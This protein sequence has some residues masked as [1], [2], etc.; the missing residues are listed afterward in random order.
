[1]AWSNVSR[2]VSDDFYEELHVTPDADARDIKKAYFGL[3]RQFPPETHPEAFQKIRA[4]Y[5]VLSDPEARKAYD[6]TRSV[7]ASADLGDELA[8]IMRS[9]LEAIELEEYERAVPLLE[10]VVKERPTAQE[11]RVQLCSCLLRLNRLADAGRE[12]QEL[13]RH[14]PTL[15]RAPLFAGYA[16]L[17][18]K[19]TAE[20]RGHFVRAALLDPLDLRPVRS[21]VDVDL[22]N[23]NGREALAWLD[24]RLAT[25]PES[26][27]LGLRMERVSV[28]LFLERGDEVTRVLNELEREAE[29]PELKEELGWFYEREA[30][31]LFA[32]RKHERAD[33]MIA[34]LMAFAPARG[35]AVLTRPVTLPISSLSPDALA[36]LVA[37]R[38]KPELVYLP[39]VGLFIDS[40]LVLVAG[41]LFGAAVMMGFNGNGVWST[42]E[43]SF[44]AL[45]FG[46][47]GATACIALRRW[48]RTMKSPVGR[49]MTLHPLY[50]IDVDIDEVRF[51]PM[52]RMSEIRA[53]HQ[54]SNGAYTHTTFA[55]FFGLESR[56]FTV[57]SQQGAED[58]AKQLY[59]LRGRLLDLLHSGLLA[60]EAG[61]DLLSAAL[62][63]QPPPRAPRWHWLRWPVAG[64]ALGV[65]LSFFAAVV[66]QRTFEQGNWSAVANDGSPRALQGYL[67][68]APA[69][70]FTESAKAA[71][72]Q[73]QR[74]AVSRLRLSA[75]QLARALEGAT[76]GTPVTLF[77]DV[78]GEAEHPVLVAPKGAQLADLPES[79]FKARG[80]RE[81]ELVE[82]LQR[83]IDAEAGPGWFVVRQGTGPLVLS[84]K[85]R[86]SLTGGAYR[87]K[88]PGPDLDLLWPEARLEATGRFGATEKTLVAS[89][90][91]VV[92][93]TRLSVQAL[94]R[95]GTSAASG[96]LFDAVW[97]DLGAQ[98]WTLLAS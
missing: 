39:G 31:A 85:Y 59:G 29:T 15:A 83:R 81:F 14:H 56:N 80:R 63:T 54:G 36:W 98:V 18:L 94:K 91:R 10:G 62:I 17:G 49:F 51:L 21:V 19:R 1:M 60:G 65:V 61:A 12:A 90:A 70:R 84:L 48:L 57:K 89:P 67:E 37:Q 52:L 71:L 66:A 4:A 3:V 35:S 32:R 73:R 97:N 76:P 24:E 50:F 77:V 30:A 43:R 27:R 74:E 75:P 33:Q 5:E 53:T 92:R 16:A 34:R 46:V 6:A 9:A 38:E 68:N 58:L 42:F 25:A 13:A 20:A 87:F 72:S 44:A 11:A 47:F 23:G 88:S 8:A 78:S 93:L 45:M 40:L 95:G 28:L 41:V 86:L 2:N 69:E 55:V 7:T 26:V 82:A 79:E 64:A 22:Q 96:A